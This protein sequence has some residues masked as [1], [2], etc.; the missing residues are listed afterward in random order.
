MSDA[1]KPQEPATQAQ[2]QASAWGLASNFTAGVIGMGFVGWALERWVWPAAA[3]WLLI[4]GIG[5]G[6]LGG[7]Y[8]F[9]RG[10]IRM[11]NS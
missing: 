11:N 5:L 8:S 4:G 9:I 2:N 3:P 7:G 6:L 10:A 1:Q